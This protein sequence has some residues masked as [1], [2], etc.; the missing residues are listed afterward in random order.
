MPPTPHPTGMLSGMST[1]HQQ[2]IAVIWSVPNM[3]CCVY[4]RSGFNLWPASVC[5]HCY[6]S[7]MPVFETSMLCVW[8]RALN[9][10]VYW[11]SLTEPT[12]TSWMGKFCPF[13]QVVCEVRLPALRIPDKCQ[14][15]S[16][17]LCAMY[18]CMHTQTWMGTSIPCKTSF[19]LP[20][21][22][23]SLTL[24]NGYLWCRLCVNN[25][26]YECMHGGN[27]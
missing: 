18:A 12:P 2:S 10:V 25:G 27:E 16:V 22:L 3:S 4:M 8:F 14:L 23:P 1:R 15:G 17:W 21:I 6:G 26:C 11:G 19:K 13:K 20:H 5:M 24:W 9:S 7:Y